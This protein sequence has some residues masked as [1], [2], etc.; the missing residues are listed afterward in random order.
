MFCILTKFGNFS[1][2]NPVYKLTNCFLHCDYEFYDLETHPWQTY[3][4]CKLL[5]GT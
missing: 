4:D 1:R 3:N 2:F 5:L